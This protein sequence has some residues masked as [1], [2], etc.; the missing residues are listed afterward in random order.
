M[1]SNAEYMLEEALERALGRKRDRFVEAYGLQSKS[2][3]VWQCMPEEAL[4]VDVADQT[5]RAAIQE[6]T[7]AFS[8]TGWWC[9]FKVGRRP[10]LVFDGL[11][12]TS[13][14]DASGWVTEVHEDGHFLAGV[15]TFPEVSAN[16]QASRPAVADFYVDA[17]RDFAL[18]AGKVYEAA[19]Y[20]SSVVVTCTMLHAN[21]LPLAGN[22]DHILAPAVK[23]QVLRWPLLRAECP[24]HVQVA[25][26]AMA[27][28]FMRAYGRA[29]P[30][31]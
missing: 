14:A 21:Q 18:V 19:S 17:F 20:T 10:A 31:G 3:L 6:G 30:K 23:R 8:D 15:W 22:R 1:K 7:N 11:A 12:S 26:S 13:D 24:G 4:A 2:A 25:C 27:A 9:G 5:L 28:Q 29:V 16:G